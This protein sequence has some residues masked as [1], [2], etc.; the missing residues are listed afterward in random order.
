MKNVEKIQ[1]FQELEYGHH[2]Y[3]KFRDAY[4][5]VYVSETCEERECEVASC[6]KRHPRRCTSFQQYRRCKFGDYCSYLHDTLKSIPFDDN[7]QSS[8][9]ETLSNLVME[10]QSK[11]T[12][13]QEKIS[14]LEHENE[15]LKNEMKNLL[16]NVK[17]TA[18]QSIVAASAVLLQK[19]SEQQDSFEKQSNFLFT[20][21]TL[22]VFQNP[23]LK[24]HWL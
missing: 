3:Y 13:M 4:G 17:I 14:V 15:S 16:V 24:Y 23:C 11:V 2:S 10:Q 9:L 6:H 19:I 1:I 18:E 22:C 20:T 5:N 8:S 12:K 21:L 7:H